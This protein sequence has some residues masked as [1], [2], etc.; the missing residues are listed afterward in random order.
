MIIKKISTVVA[1]IPLTRPH[2]M[3]LMTVSE[4]N[5]LFVR[6]EGDNGAVG[7]GETSFLGGPT[8][9]EESVESAAAV[10]ERYVGPYLIGKSFA[11]I[12]EIRHFMET[13]IRGNHFALAAV[14]LAL[15]DLLG[16]SLNLPVYQLL[17]GMVRDKVPMSWSLAAGSIEADLKE[18]EEMTAKGNFIFKFKTGLK[19]VEED[20]ER[21][22][23]VRE[24]F[25]KASLRA[26]ANQGWDR[27]KGLRACSLFEPYNLDFIEQPVPKTDMDSLEYINKHSNVPI[28]A[29]ESLESIQAATQL[30]KREAVGVF[31]IKLS[32]AGGLLG[33]KR[34]AAIAEGAGFPCYVGSMF[35][36]PL[37]NAAHLHFCCSTPQ[38]T[39]GCELFGPML[40]QDQVTEE[41]TGFENGY[42]LLDKDKP[43]FGITMNE[44]K[45]KKYS[46]NGFVN[47]GV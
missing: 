31:G 45:L 32:K 22:K 27:A 40:L 16:K 10:V 18:A 5:Y 30:V 38:V 15:W 29:D 14:E 34:L 9:S 41:M 17:G 4:V 1:D 33:A 13:L 25:P 39:L 35:E 11:N 19:S 37:C 7:W 36:T 12:E 42:V 20:A 8:W 47:V 23:C 3:S 44:T 26:D 21:I 6:I 2:V 46:R 43:G 28:M 24:A